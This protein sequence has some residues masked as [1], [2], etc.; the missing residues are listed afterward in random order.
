MCLGGGSW[1]RL[2]AGLVSP[3]FSRSQPMSDGEWR[4]RIRI[5]EGGLL[6]QLVFRRQGS[7]VSGQQ[8]SPGQHCGVLTNGGPGEED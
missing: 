1:Q 2:K 8:E 7:V 5:V 6:L 4:S 3:S